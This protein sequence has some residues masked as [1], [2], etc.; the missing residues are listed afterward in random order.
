MQAD[1]AVEP[2]VPVSMYLPE[3]QLEH[4]VEAEEPVFG[5]QVPAGQSVHAVFPVEAIFG[6]YFPA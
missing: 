4:V 3:A 5:D 1:S 6:V 2:V